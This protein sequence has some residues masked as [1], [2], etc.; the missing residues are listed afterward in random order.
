MLAMLG[1]F[2]SMVCVGMYVWGVYLSPAF[3]CVCAVW[4]E[5]YQY[6]KVLTGVAV[7]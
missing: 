2:V 5:G 7:C 1:M 4:S 6:G 3:F